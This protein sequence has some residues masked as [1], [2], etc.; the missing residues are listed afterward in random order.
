MSDKPF[1]L[2]YGGI[3]SQWYI[4]YFEVDGVQ[5]NCAEQFMMRQKALLFGDT[6]T[7]E[8]IMREAHPRDQKA[9]GKIVHGK[10]GGKW[11]IEDI[12][13]WNSKARDIVYKG[14]W[15]K[16]DQN[17]GL[18]ADLLMYKDHEFVEAS[19][20]DRVWGIGLGEYDEKALDK[21][22]WQ[23][24]NWLGEVINKVVEDFEVNT[25]RTEGFNWSS[26]NGD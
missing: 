3:C 18:K 23:G 6:E 11:T 1:K 2:F 4:C 20:Y 19:P 10:D 16:F 26:T 8:K 25:Y 7:A 14:N 22:Q 9:L 13:L 5:Y 17:P 21:S 24:T 15:H 12:A